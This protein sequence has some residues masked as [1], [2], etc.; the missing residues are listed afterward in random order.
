[1]AYQ[2][3]TDL[4]LLLSWQI[5]VSYGVV[6]LAAKLFKLFNTKKHQVKILH[7]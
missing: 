6:I 2:K 5:M 1:M 7:N 4:R 3:V